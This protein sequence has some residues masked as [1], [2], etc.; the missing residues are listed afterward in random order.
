[1]KQKETKK[2]ESGPGHGKFHDD[3]TTKWSFARITFNTAIES[4]PALP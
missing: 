1:M 4:Y 3:E 2:K